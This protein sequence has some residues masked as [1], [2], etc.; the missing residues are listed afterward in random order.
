MTVGRLSRIMQLLVRVMRWMGMKN[1]SLDSLFMFWLCM[2]FADYRVSC[3]NCHGSNDEFSWLLSRVMRLLDTS[4]EVCDGSCEYWAWLSRSCDDWT[5][6]LNR[7][8]RLL[9]KTVTGHAMTRHKFQI[10]SRFDDWRWLLR[11]W[12]LMTITGY[13]MTGHEVWRLSWVMRS[14]D[15]TVT[16]DTLNVHVCSLDCHGSS[17]GFEPHRHHWSPRRAFRDTGTLAKNLKGYGI[18]L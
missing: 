11:V 5:W 15:I 14:S 2:C 4:W 13:A 10:L 17:N 6:V 12:V 18:F 3:N 7:F 1:R 9:Y 16:V 8:M